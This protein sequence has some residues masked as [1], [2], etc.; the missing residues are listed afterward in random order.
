MLNM[1]PEAKACLLQLASRSSI[2]YISLF[3]GRGCIY[4]SRIGLEIFVVCLFEISHWF[5]VLLGQNRLRLREG[6]RSM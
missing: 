2:R 5:Q 3:I 6:L 4:C 1:K